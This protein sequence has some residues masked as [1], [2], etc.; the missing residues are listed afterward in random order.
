MN[1]II[2][3]SPTKA[4]T[5]GKFLGKSYKVVSSLGHIRDLPQ[6]K[7]GIDKEH[8]FAPDYVIPPKSRKIVS[9]LKK[10]A[11]RAG[12]IYLATDEDREGEAI[13]WHLENILHAAPDK[14]SRIAFHEITEEAVRAALE[15]PRIVDLRLVNAQQ[16]RRIL[17]RLVGYELSPFL[18]RKVARGLS[19][20]RVQSVA[21]RLIVERER[22]I[23][24][25][26]AEEYWT[27]EG[28]F[29]KSSAPDEFVKA[30]LVAIDAK[31][32]EKFAIKTEEDAKKLYSFLKNGE[33]KVKRVQGKDSV[34]N[35]QPPF[36]T[37]TLQQE[38]NRR[39]GYSA[40]QIMLLAQ[41]LYEGI[42]LG[43]EGTVGLITYMRTDSVNLSEKFIGET[44]EYLRK[45]YG[46]RFV[47]K[48]PTHF[49]T[50]VK[51][52]QEAHE[53]IRPT[54]V[55]RTPELIK[56]YLEPQTWHLYDLIWR[57][58]VATQMPSAVFS[59]T[60][61]DIQTKHNGSEYIFRAN[62]AVIKSPGFLKIYPSEIKE[63]VLPKLVE[64]DKL[65]PKDL[66]PLQHFTEPPA[67]FTDASLVKTLEE[68][69]IGR[70]ST[71]AP[72]IST[73]IERKYVERTEGRKLA[74]TELAFLVNDI[75]VEHFPDVVDYKFTAAMEDDLDKIAD[76]KKEWVQVI[77]Y[78]Y[79]PFWENLLRKDKEIS[80]E[81]IINETT[82]EVCGLCGRKMAV[83]IG[84]FG[85]FLACSGFPECR[86]TRPLKEDAEKEAEIVAN[87]V[88]EKC[89]APLVLKHGPFGAF[90]NCSNYPECKNIKNI[91]KSTG[92]ICPECGK[93]EIME[94]KSRRG[95]MF[96]SCGQ[97]PDCKFAL[98]QRPT[99]EKCPK[100]GSL[101][102]CGPK[103]II[104]CSKEE[105]DYRADIQQ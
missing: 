11:V 2:V 94:R 16:A 35:P 97:Y 60:I 91:E 47:S 5:I 22:A 68:Y 100:C 95:R 76:G 105:C 44:R 82:D 23:K 51:N 4:R 69:G 80:K 84:R 43:D 7:L 103:K 41:Q 19:A 89:G 14:V 58:A 98:W 85:K 96:Y 48:S 62:G 45:N 40:K 15:H 1:L 86:S 49:K 87:R 79:I 18:W 59:A 42:D 64:G 12:K 37:S 67:R 28:G 73:V 74:P 39:L 56:P 72:I 53:A 17:D 30:K 33:F 63:T 90:L 50:R 75:L 29:I 65:L 36:I 31:N 81:D 10:V 57:K 9:D 3:E 104:K 24:A 21:L 66:R 101:L 13:S 52:A 46:E 8:D 71:Y 20:G 55:A 93:G 32:L 99:G 26:Q 102:V 61:I 77:R 25:F 34:R 54:S 27:I 92:A 6:S 78:F 83:K 88:C 70:P 38:A